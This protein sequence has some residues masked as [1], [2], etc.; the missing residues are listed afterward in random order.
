MLLD[1]VV[2]V[3]CRPSE[4]GNVGAVCRAMMNCGLSRLALTGPDL[5]I[6]ENEE[7][8]AVVLA[9]CVHAAAIWRKRRVYPSLAEA[10]KD[11]SLLVGTSRRRGRHRK[12]ITLS[13]HE[14]ALYVKERPG[15][16]APL[17]LVF[18]NER[19]GLETGELELCT[20]A[21]H[22]PANDVFPSFNLSHAVQIY[23][24]ELFCALSPLAA[25]D[26][27]EAWKPIDR[28]AVDELALSVTKALEGIGFYKQITREYQE[29]F[30][31][32]I[33]SRAALTADEAVYMRGVFEK[34][35]RLARQA[36]PD[37]D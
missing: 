18:G 13:A 12:N 31:R 36:L 5:A 1:E 22:I 35:A 3:L 16:S 23:C 8:E 29:R 14:A 7:A 27:P 32:D 9:R 15:G 20:V 11:F 34:A 4:P 25:R 2:V 26:V 30:F 28:R 6:E 21:S 17:A 19:T 37:A 33:F 10:A 24:Y